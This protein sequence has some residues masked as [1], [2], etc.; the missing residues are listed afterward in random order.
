M[1]ILGYLF[2]GLTI[3]LFLI[4]G[5]FVPEAP[6]ESDYGY[7]YTWPLYLMI[8]GV[9]VGVAL[10]LVDWNVRRQKQGKTRDETH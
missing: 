10:L 4:F 6:M 8:V 9:T 1:R 7:T 5:L 2:I 3:L